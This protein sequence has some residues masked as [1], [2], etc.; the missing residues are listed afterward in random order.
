MS[1]NPSTKVKVEVKVTTSSNMER[2]IPG[3]SSNTSNNTRQ[4]VLTALF[5]ALVTVA[6]MVIQVPTFATQGYINVGDTMIFVAA[7]LMGPRTG[8]IAGGLGSALADLFSG[9]AHWAPWTLV[10]KG[11]EGL[12]VGLIAHRA[13]RSK[14]LLSPI[15]I[16]TMV[17]AA[18]WM[19]L[20]Y[21]IGGGVM[22]GFAASITEIPGNLIQGLGSIVLATPVLAILRKVDLTK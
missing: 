18:L 9:Y 20:G 3:A 4:L 21:Y 6:T 1:G 13:Y 15:V 17:V 2:N 14:G 16:P 7:A 12:I 22:K 19:V 11:L 5:A 8:L 10:I